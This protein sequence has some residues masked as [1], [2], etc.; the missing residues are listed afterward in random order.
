MLTL[1]RRTFTK[2]DQI[3][4]PPSTLTSISHFTPANPILRSPL[5]IHFDN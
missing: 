5:V 4:S 1:T 3:K 2:T